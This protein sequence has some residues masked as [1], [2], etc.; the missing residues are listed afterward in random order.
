MEKT[1]GLSCD[2]V[3]SSSN[4]RQRRPYVRGRSRYRCELSS[5]GVGD[6]QR[7]A[8]GIA[9]KRLVSPLARASSLGASPRCQRCSLKSCSR[10]A[11]TVGGWIATENRRHPAFN[12]ALCLI[13]LKRRHVD[14]NRFTVRTVGARGPVKV[15]AIAT[16]AG[17]QPIVKILAAQ[18]TSRKPHR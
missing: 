13:G 18:R 11:S 8:A 9:Q 10:W 3:T 16:V 7:F 6:F 2:S 14:S 17:R 1:P 12:A 15:I 4:R 5:V